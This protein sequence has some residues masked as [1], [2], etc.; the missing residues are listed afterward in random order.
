MELKTHRVS[1]NRAAA[2]AQH[3]SCI[4]SIVGQL[5]GVGEMSAGCLKHIALLLFCTMGWSYASSLAIGA[6]S[7][8][9]K[10]SIS[11]Q[12]GDVI[13]SLSDSAGDHTVDKT[14]S[15]NVGSFGLIDIHVQDL[16]LSQVL[17]LLSIESQRNIIVSRNVSGR[18]SADLYQ[19][20]FYEALDAILQANGFG[21]RERGNF[22]YVYTIDELQQILKDERQHVTRVFRLNYLTAKNASDYIALALSTSGTTAIS[23]DIVPSFHA[24]DGD[25]GANTNGLGEILVVRDYSENVEEISKILKELDVRPKQVRVEATILQ[26]KLDENNAFGIDISALINF[27]F[28]AFSDPL[29]VV[30]DLIGGTSNSETGF[31][32]QS[33]VGQTDSNHSGVKIGILGSNVSAFIKALD[34]VTDVT[35]LAKP[36]ILAINRMK[37]DILVGERLGYI[38]TTASETSTTQTVE[39]LDVGTKLSFRAFIN[40]DGYI[41]LELKPSAS[42]GSTALVGGMVIPN[43]VTSEL[44]S[45][46]RV[47]SGQTIVLG[48]LFKESTKVVRRQMPFVGA[49]PVVGEAFRGQ[50]DEVDRDEIIFLIT[51]TVVKDE[52]MWSEGASITNGIERARIGAN[53]GL[54]PFSRTKMVAAH[55]REALDYYRE[56]RNDKA[57]WKVNT[58]LRLDRT[59]VEGLRLKELL[60]RQSGYWPSH[61]I[62]EDAIDTTIQQRIDHDEKEFDENEAQVWIDKQTSNEVAQVN[63]DP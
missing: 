41:R 28:G 10:E 9:W 57:L 54:L 23:S 12:E 13:R 33:T 7:D 43:E 25:V 49:L 19:V 14:K 21:F 55:M 40:D 22:I 39:F 63:V 56:G 45:N 18:I 24:S 52:E 53:Q 42:D 20:D 62:L 51:T 44:T 58:A 31:G 50:D 29:G 16:E 2:R 34:E 6:D 3:Q 37:A 35:V 30:D 60:M 38:S 17:K 61:S 36:S 59:I 48:G 5:K 4:I 8:D 47:R 1:V 11:N 27:S 32:G 15:V 46:V 26:A